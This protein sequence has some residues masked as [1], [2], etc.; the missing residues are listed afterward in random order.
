MVKFFSRVMKNIVGEA[1][2]EE[3]EAVNYQGSFGTGAMCY[4][5]QR[6]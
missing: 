5:V 3:A 4:F 2:K 6:I 1:L